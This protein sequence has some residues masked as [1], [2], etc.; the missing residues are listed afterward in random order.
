LTTN[1][2]TAV[3]VLLSTTH[4]GLTGIEKAGVRGIDGGLP[5][6]YGI[7]LEG[8]TSVF[9]PLGLGRVSLRVD[10]SLDTCC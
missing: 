9:E 6:P 4:V 7:K 1:A 5:V 3:L 10:E 8:G 2:G